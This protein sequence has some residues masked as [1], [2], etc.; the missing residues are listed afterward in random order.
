LDSKLRAPRAGDLK[1]SASCAD[2]TE[3]STIPERFFS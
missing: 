2:P 1:D 3:L